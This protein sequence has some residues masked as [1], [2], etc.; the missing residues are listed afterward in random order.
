[1]RLTVLLD[2]ESNGS[3]DILNFPRFTSVVNTVSQI[4]SR[5]VNIAQLLQWAIGSGHYLIMCLRRFIAC[6]SSIL[7]VIVSGFI[8]ILDVSLSSVSTVNSELLHEESDIT[9]LVDDICADPTPNHVPTIF[10][11]FNVDTS[12]PLK[13]NHEIPQCS[14]FVRIAVSVKPDCVCIFILWE[15]QTFLNPVIE[16]TNSLWADFAAPVSFA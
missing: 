2:E 13:F 11:A 15:F 3:S 1:V 4:S 9:P 14:L 6:S 5:R 7:E 16:E 12:F 10:T 8:C